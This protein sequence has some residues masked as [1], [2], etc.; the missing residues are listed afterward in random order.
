LERLSDK[1]AVCGKPCG[2]GGADLSGGRSGG[3]RGG[4]DIEVIGWLVLVD[5]GEDGDLLEAIR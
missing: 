5:L 2:E 3:G 1:V 4:G